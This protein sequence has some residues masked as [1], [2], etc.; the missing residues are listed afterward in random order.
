MSMPRHPLR[1]LLWLLVLA[2]SPLA[3]APPEPIAADTWLLRGEFVPGRQPDGNSVILQGPEGLVVI[4]S[5]RHAAHSERLLSFVAQRGQAV[6][7]LV[8]THWHLDHVGG[9]PRLRA[10]HPDLVVHASDA[11][12]AALEGF[13]A[14]SRAQLRAMLERESD[15][16]RARALREEIA[17]IESGAQLR[18]DLVVSAAGERELAGRRLQFGLEAAA[19]TAGDVWVYDPATRVLVAGDLVTLP[20]PFLDT[21]CPARWQAALA[22]LEQ[23]P[24]EQLIPGHGAPLTRSAFARYRGAFDGLLAC[25]ASDAPPA[26]CVARWREAAGDL[27]DGTP[28][29]QVGGLVEYYVTQR[30]RGDGASADCP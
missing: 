20:A 4:D 27:L 5:G 3:A 1:P 7:A 12:D 8:N 28:P 15:P 21:A 22:R 25:A 16:E 9:N 17:R 23:V 11:I 13:L 18:P 24:F 30:L 6:R 26:Q 2:A 14:R 10:A 19:V 29:E